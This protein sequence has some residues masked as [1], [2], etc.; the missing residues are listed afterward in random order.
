MGPL[1]GNSV[2]VVNQKRILEESAASHNTQPTNSDA[3]DESKGLGR[4]GG[5]P[6]GVIGIKA[7]WG[8]RMPPLRSPRPSQQICQK[9]NVKNTL[10]ENEP[11]KKKKASKDV[12]ELCVCH[13]VGGCFLPKLCPKNI[14]SELY[15]QK[16]LSR[17]DFVAKTCE[18]S[19]C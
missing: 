15:Y 9:K 14:F 4:Y 2:L 5:V 10:T 13:C 3:R 11:K 19:S 8:Y 12:S 7:H 17:K 1:S 16:H 18:K 6:R